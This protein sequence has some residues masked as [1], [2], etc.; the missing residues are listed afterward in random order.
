MYRFAVLCLWSQKSGPFRF[1]SSALTVLEEDWS[2]LAEECAYEWDYENQAKF[3]DDI[4]MHLADPGLVKFPFVEI[5][6][7][8]GLH[9]N[10]ES[11]LWVTYL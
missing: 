5:H 10:S 4:S 3:L 2:W 9:A 8:L 11:N 7:S 6:Q 1:F